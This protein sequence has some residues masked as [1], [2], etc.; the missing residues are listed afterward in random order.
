MLLHCLILKKKQYIFSKNVFDIKFI[1]DKKQPLKF[2]SNSY[3]AKKGR[4][5]LQ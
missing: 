5:V 2:E 3:F 4:Q 1:K